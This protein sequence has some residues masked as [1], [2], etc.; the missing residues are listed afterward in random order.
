MFDHRAEPGNCES[1]SPDEVDIAQGHVL[2]YAVRISLHD[3]RERG[4]INGGGL[5]HK[6]V[7]HECVGRRAVDEDVTNLNRIKV[8]A[9]VYP[10]EA[11]LRVDWLHRLRLQY[12]GAEVGQ[13]EDQSKDS[14]DTGKSGG[15]G[16]EVLKDFHFDLRPS[17]KLRWE[18]LCRCWPPGLH[19]R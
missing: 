9:G 18:M 10:A 12:E 14:D 11:P 3:H 17:Q 7:Q 4:G 2:R 1:L 16:D 6:P 8:H 13:D 15:D 19:S 5:L